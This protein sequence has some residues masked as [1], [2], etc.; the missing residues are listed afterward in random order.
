MD[1]L[2][3]SDLVIGSKRKMNKQKTIL[4]MMVWALSVAGPMLGYGLII[5]TRRLLRG[6]SLL[7][8]DTSGR[9]L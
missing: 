8:W 7:S 4:V 5:L 9:G 1:G 6:P 2:T 3:E